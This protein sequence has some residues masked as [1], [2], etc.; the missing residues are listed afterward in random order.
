MDA[1]LF[2]YPMAQDWQSELYS[3]SSGELLALRQAN[4]WRGLFRVVA[5]GFPMRSVV[6]QDATFLLLHLHSVANLLLNEIKLVPAL[7]EFYLFLLE[8]QR[9][10]GFISVPKAF[11]SAEAALLL[12]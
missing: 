11:Y 3:L 6:H 9:L 12:P 4:W 8:N 2:Q 7:R 5:P 10:T 1:L